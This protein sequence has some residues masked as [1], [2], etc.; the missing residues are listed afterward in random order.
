VNTPENATYRVH[1]G[2][3]NCENGASVRK[4]T[5][6]RVIAVSGPK[7]SSDQIAAPVAGIMDQGGMPTLR[8]ILRR[9]SKNE[10]GRSGPGK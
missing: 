8:V 3:K 7:V 2:W 4:G 5:T 10:I 1:S 9:V 6:S